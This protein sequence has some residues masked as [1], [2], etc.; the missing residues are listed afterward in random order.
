[1]ARNRN[2][3]ERRG[4]IPTNERVTLRALAHFI[5]TLI[6]VFEIAISRAGAAT[7]GDL[8][9]DFDP[10]EGGSN[11]RGVLIQPD[12][13][14]LV[15]GQFSTFNGIP[16]RGLVRLNTN[17]TVDTTF[18]PDC[19]TNAVC[20]ALQKS[21]KIL[22]AEFKPSTRTSK[23]IRLNTNGSLDT[24]FQTNLV[25]DNRVRS[26]I[27]R[28]DGRFVVVGDFQNVSA[29]PRNRVAGVL[30]G[31][32]LDTNFNVGSGCDAPVYTGIVEPGGKIIIG[33]KFSFAGGVATTY[34]ARLHTNGAVDQTFVVNSSAYGGFVQALA[35]QENGSVLA[36]Y[37][38]S[39]PSLRR[40]LPNGTLDD[41]L[42]IGTEFEGS[43][44]AIVQLFPRRIF[45]AGIFPR[46]DG[47]PI[48]SWGRIYDTGEIDPDFQMGV[49]AYGGIVGA[50]SQTNGDIVIAGNF[51]SI[52]ETPRQSVARLTG[53][54]PP[55]TAPSITI[56]PANITR[57]EGEL[58]TVSVTAEGTGPLDYQWHKDGELI[59]NS[60]RRSGANSPTLKLFSATPSDSGVYTVKITSAFGSTVSSN[61]T[62][63]VIDSPPG[64]HP[65]S[66][67][68]N[69][70]SELDSPYHSI[71]EMFEL[72]DG[73]LF[74]S[75]F[76]F[77]R[78]LGR[79]G[80]PQPALPF[81]TNNPTGAIL[82][83]PNG[84]MILGCSGQGTPDRPLPILIRYLTNGVPDPTFTPE[85]T[86]T[87]F[88]VTQLARQIDGK[89]I[90]AGAFPD[91]Q[92]EF[93]TTLLRF[94]ANGKR[95]FGFAWNSDGDP[96]VE[97]ILPLQDGSFLMSQEFWEASMGT[98]GNLSRF[99]QDGSQN[100]SFR[101]FSPTE[102]RHMRIHALCQQPDGKI[103]V[104]GAFTSI[105]G[106]GR[107]NLARLNS[108][109]SLDVTFVSDTPFTVLDISLQSD[110]KILAAGT[111]ADQSK[112]RLVRC[113][114][115]GSS[116]AA[117]QFGFAT[118]GRMTRVLPSRFGGIYVAGGFSDPNGT[119]SLNPSI[120]RLNNDGSAPRPGMTPSISSGPADRSMHEGTFDHLTLSAHG[121]GSLS[122][123][124]FRN[125]VAVTNQGDFSGAKSET[126]NFTRVTTASAGFYHAIVTNAW[127]TATSAVAQVLVNAPR[128]TA[129][130]VDTGFELALPS[131]GKITIVAAGIAGWLYSVRETTSSDGSR[132]SVIERWNSDGSRDEFFGPGVPWENLD[133]ICPQSDGKLLVSER[134]SIGGLSSL[135]R[136]NMDG[137]SDDLFFAKDIASASP[138]AVQNG[139]TI[140]AWASFVNPFDERH[141]VRLFPGGQLDDSFQ[142]DPAKVKFTSGIKTLVIQ[143]DQKILAGGEFTVSHRGFSNYCVNLARFEPDGSLDSSFR[144]VLK[145][146][147]GVDTMAV[148]RFGRVLAFGDFQE[149]DGIPV[150]S[151]A[152]LNPDGSF[153]STLGIQLPGSS[154]EFPKIAVQDDGKIIFGGGPL[155][156]GGR[157]YRGLFRVE[158]DGGP[159]PTFDPG[160][161]PDGPIT[162]FTLVPGGIA[163]AGEFRSFDHTPRP[164]LVRI[165]IA[166]KPGSPRI[167]TQSPPQRLKAGMAA[168]L[169]IT[170][171]GV[172]P[173]F[174]FWRLNSTNILEASGPQLFLPNLASSDSGSY[175][176]VVSN[177]FGTASASMTLSVLSPPALLKPERVGD[178]FRFPFGTADGLPMTAFDLPRFRILTST[179]LLDWNEFPGE[180]FETNGKIYFYD[181]LRPTPQSYYQVTEP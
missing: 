160:S 149:V 23:I 135:H 60:R 178:T 177:Q 53:G 11:I 140:L 148:D 55:P 181:L 48:P 28:G 42:Q 154:T 92:N 91:S 137:T 84:K 20:F 94:H 73:R 157:E 147:G 150:S 138:I 104:G 86:D 32:N 70:F 61:A 71:D 4:G 165:R 37:D 85:L 27:V 54:I 81:L 64:T 72:P 127:G 7:P 156:I 52:A 96:D 38:N 111:L 146:S 87:S 51:T 124:W 175:S 68:L 17:G 173:L 119:S 167:Q 164:G 33:G 144:A 134:L 143:P 83:E 121:S 133:Y 82:R 14:I 30:P 34:I 50:A 49:G 162:D 179:N 145:G 79:D 105:S 116:D 56:Q 8:D 19:T 40:F 13:K 161:G 169:S 46:V 10:G 168:R 25:F 166:P 112:A 18:V 102:S 63:I 151:F 41:S 171:S 35:L 3:L 101:P 44:C 65:G 172:S 26:I 170:V 155:W 176:V 2:A 129:G 67:D 158:S 142:I 114:P 141:L 59:P 130:S 31:G 24:A 21:G 76:V 89:I 107:T 113:N 125:G 117:F 115:D 139:G 80:E 47:I 45:L 120:E 36:G 126:L 12:Q 5:Y 15:Q 58:V 6:V 100:R 123:Q 88:Y 97:K 99:N 132:V 22:L 90:V 174:Y 39:V 74:V 78:L 66:V 77:A 1:V 106:M 180:L 93:G 69:F 108:D 163:A 43:V 29:L 95:D 159:D 98:S 109:G 118:P 103:L 16:R 57:N 122:F 152:R 136:L 128:S 110:G 62:V 153:D 9:L 131:D 75:G